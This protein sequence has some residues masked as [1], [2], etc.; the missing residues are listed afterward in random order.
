MSDVKHAQARLAR[1]EERQRK[2]P[3]SVAAAREV[4]L[5]RAALHRALREQA[6]AAGQRP[7]F[8][9]DP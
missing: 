4:E 6:V 5:A 2:C 7:L 3:W 9:G 1:A 8:E